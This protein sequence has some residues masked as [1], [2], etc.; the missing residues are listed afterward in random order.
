[1]T[2]SPGFSGHPSLSLAHREVSA[3]VC[4]YHSF[5]GLW[6][7]L[8]LS[9]ELKSGLLNHIGYILSSISIVFSERDF[10]E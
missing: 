6:G 7:F 3:F 9:F 10:S 5:F 2:I 1:M 8:L 4:T